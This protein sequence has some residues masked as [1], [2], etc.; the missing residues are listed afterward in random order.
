MKL[1]PIG[2]ALVFLCT[3]CTSLSLERYTLNQVATTTD[4]RFQEVL[5]NLATTAANPGTLPAY[6][7][8][9]DGTTTVG[10]TYS[11]DSKTAWARATFKGFTTDSM[12]AVGTFNPSPQWTVSPVAT[13]DQLTALQAALKWVVCGPAP[14]NSPEKAILDKFQV[15]KDL[16]ELPGGWLGIGK[17][18]EA[19]HCAVYKSHCKGTWVWVTPAGMQGF[20]RFTIIVQD[21][22]TVDVASLTPESP[23]LTLKLK[24]APKDA[25]GAKDSTDANTI[26]VTLKDDVRALIE[27]GKDGELHNRITQ[28]LASA[29]QGLGLKT[30]NERFILPPTFG[31]P[32]AMEP[33]LDPQPG[34]RPGPNP[35][36]V[37]PAVKSY[38]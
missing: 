34:P 5:N 29:P 2:T 26:E 20:S 3:G 12:A 4:M 19:P 33:N 35:T 15:Y 6:A 28:I 11:F 23:T 25:K 21:I 24:R 30:K 16:S 27:P 18:K 13:A 14:A 7:S 10:D 31:I 9:S 36:Q 8:I 37:Q 22:A 1:T 32:T 17:C 38:R